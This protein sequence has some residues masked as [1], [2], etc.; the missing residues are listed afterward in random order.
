MASS[1]VRESFDNKNTLFK[2]TNFI[3]RK[4]NTLAIVIA[5]TAQCCYHSGYCFASTK[6]ESLSRL[7]FQFWN[8]YHCGAWLEFDMILYI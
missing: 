8:R 3:V 1:I 5:S 6:Y 4:E 7:K 2:E